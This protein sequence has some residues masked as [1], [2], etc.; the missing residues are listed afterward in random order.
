MK[1]MIVVALMGVFLLSGIQA[2]G[3]PTNGGTLT[4][5]NTE[6][7]D[8]THTVFTEFGSTTSCS[9]CP[10][11][12][13]ALKN[14]Y[15]GGWYP[16]YYI[17]LALG[18]NTH[19]DARADEYNLYYIPD[20][21]FD[22]GYKV[23]C[24]SVNDNIQ[25]TMD[26]FNTSITQ[27]GNRVVPDIETIL[28]VNWLGNATMNI[29]VSVQ[30]KDPAEYDGHIRVYVTEVES[31]MGWKDAQN[32]PYTFAFLDYA[33][34]ETISIDPSG[35]WSDAITW[36]GHNYDDGHSHNFGNIQYGNIMVIAAVFNA[37][38]HTAYSDDPVSFLHPFTAYNVDDATG[39]LIG[40]TGP[41]P[42]SNP[43]PKNGATAVDISKILSWTGGGSPGTTIS[44]DVYFGPTNPPAMVV[45][46][47]SATTYNPGIMTYE[48]TYYWK[49]V[50]WDQD[51]NTMAGPTWHFTT[52]NNPNKPPNLPTITGPAKGKPNTIYRFT[53]TATDPDVND[54]MLEGFIDWG[55]NT[56]TNWIG[57]YHASEPFSVTHSW[58]TQDTFAVKVKIRDQHGAESGWATLDIKIPTDYGM[59]HPFLQWL[60]DH[61]PNAFPLLRHLLS[62]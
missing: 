44:Y 28:T 1:K 32:H 26:Q 25:Q 36:D 11:V 51:H 31:S 24:G 8:F 53:V 2:V 4:S 27:C 55:D 6:N 5:N 56:T 9:H 58:D 7:R 33:F 41:Y 48:T 34:N 19:A 57:P 39:F 54:T 52:F 3:L 43:D 60:F 50:A 13:M 46:N 12:H 45:H 61:F 29:Q 37:T 49:I 15:Y 20:T 30:N 23:Y 47:Q 42:P 38:G 59:T 35:T 22:G 62:A 17:S 21:F 40:G 10:Y 16:F 18:H 14:I